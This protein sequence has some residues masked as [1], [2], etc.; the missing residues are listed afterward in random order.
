MGAG[1]NSG[2]SESDQNHGV[3]GDDRQMP[4]IFVIDQQGGPQDIGDVDHSGDS[5]Q[6]RETLR[7]LLTSWRAEKSVEDIRMNGVATANDGAYPLC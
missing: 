7:V 2:V 3:G 1:G 6:V 4:S 5:S